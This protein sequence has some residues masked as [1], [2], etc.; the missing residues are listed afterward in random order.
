MVLEV[1]LGSAVILKLVKST[2]FRPW[3]RGVGFD[4]GIGSGFRPWGGEWVSTVEWGVGI[5][6]FINRCIKA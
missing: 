1:T 3:G 5:Q 6:E 2:V 4:L